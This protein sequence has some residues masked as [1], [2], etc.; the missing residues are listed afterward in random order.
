[1]NFVRF[2][3]SYVLSIKCL[4]QVH[5]NVNCNT[6]SYY[7]IVSKKLLWNLLHSSHIFLT[8]TLLHLHIGIWS[9]KQYYDD[10]KSHRVVDKQVQIHMIDIVATIYRANIFWQYTFVLCTLTCSGV[11]LHTLFTFCGGTKLELVFEYCVV[12]PRTQIF[13]YVHI[14]YLL[15]SLLSYCPLNIF[16]L[17]TQF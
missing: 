4:W 3:L 16:V 6:Q 11:F 12:F 10:T 13:T 15:K 14:W 8:L 2:I 17:N 9:C 5:V 1:M 7:V